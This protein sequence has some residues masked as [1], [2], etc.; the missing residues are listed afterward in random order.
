MNNKQKIV[1][2]IFTPVIV[3][4]LMRLVFL[5]LDVIANEWLNLR[6]DFLD[7]DAQWMFDIGMYWVFWL[8]SAVASLFLILYIIQ[9]EN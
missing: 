1:L 2:A 5:L 4:L 9:D 6:L 7:I 8:A 3:T